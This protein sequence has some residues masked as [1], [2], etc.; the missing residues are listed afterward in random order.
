MEISFPGGLK[1]TAHYKGMEIPTDQPKDE[2]GDGSAP[3]PF[4]LFLASI[5]TCAGV[6]AVSF[7]RA[8]KIPTQGMRLIQHITRDPKTHKIA[9]L[10]LELVLPPEFPAKYEK[11]IIRVMDLCAVKKAIFNPP[12]INLRAVRS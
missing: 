9:A 10:D 3:E 4:T 2:G 5:A 11:A 7:C 1:V 6:Y 8:R 12:E